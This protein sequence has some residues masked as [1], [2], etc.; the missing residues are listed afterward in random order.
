MAVF[1]LHQVEEQYNAG[2]H[3]CAACRR[4]GR[5]VLRLRFWRLELCGRVW[6]LRRRYLRRCARCG[7][8]ERLAAGPAGVEPQDLSA[9]DLAAAGLAAAA[10]TAETPPGEP[11]PPSPGELPLAGPEAPPPARGELYD[12]LRRRLDLLL[13]PPG[14]EDRGRLLA[15]AHP[16]V[17]GILLEYARR[18]AHGLVRQV[19]A[20]PGEPLGSPGALERVLEDELF[21]AGWAGYTCYIASMAARGHGAGPA[22]AEPPD[23]F[24]RRVGAL[25]A[26]R[27]ERGRH[28]V[29]PEVVAWISDHA[30]AGPG[31]L[32][33]RGYRPPPR[34]RPALERS[35]RRCLFLGYA[36]GVEE[37]R[38]RS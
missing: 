22:P 23:Q 27:A 11:P 13:S 4:D 19:A 24:I 37:G 7:A 33:E 28:S 12:R 34:L 20:V 3:F 17:G 36:V 32:T 6:E 8:E 1:Y 14:A 21:A 38:Y 35:L 25:A 2:R 10:G 5:H 15:G 31:R 16:G 29:L 30:A 9:A 18:E 26:K